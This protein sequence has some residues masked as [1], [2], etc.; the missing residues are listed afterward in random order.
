MHMTRRSALLSAAA[1]ALSGCAPVG[2]SQVASTSEDPALRP[3]PNPAYDAWIAAFR[4]RAIERGIAPATLDA[5]FRGA[6]YLPGVVERDR[7]QTEFRR[8]FEDYLA[9]VASEEKV[10]QGRRAFQRQQSLLAQIE[11]RYGV[12]ADV[13]A[14]IWGVES[15]YGVRRG[16]I[17][18]ISATSTLAFD[19]RRGRFFEQQL[20]AAL[21]IL[22]NGDIDAARMTGSWAGAMGHTQFIPTTFETYGVDFEGDGRRDI[23]SDDPTDGLASAAAYLSRS[24]WQRGRPAAIEV[25]LPQGFAP[26][27]TG[28]N[29]RRS[30]DAWIGSGV[31]TATGTTLPDHGSASILIPSGP[32]G[33]AFLV[34][35]NF[36]VLLRYNNSENYALGV[37]YLSQRIRGGSGLIAEFPPD[38]FGLTIDMRRDLQRRLTAAGYDTGGTDGVIGPK[39]EAAIRA[40][41]QAAGLPV[42]G[43]PSAS[44][45]RRLSS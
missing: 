10:A 38:R 35:R 33:P 29:T 30:T 9:I 28:R 23:W 36:S 8:S 43:Q 45:L 12:A 24:G 26:S 5:A 18:V 39:S 31:K 32:A 6:G 44:L 3:A 17:P 11:A 27:L 34:Y 22:Q 7:N 19:G 20:M 25:R 42:N 16:S 2:G 13:V 40:Y 37:S 15:N 4:S 21:R 1:V 14:A 41:Q